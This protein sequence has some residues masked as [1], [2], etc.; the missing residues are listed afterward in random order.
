MGGWCVRGGTY[1]L[2]EGREGGSGGGVL[3]TEREGTRMASVDLVPAV[4]VF[5]RRFGSGC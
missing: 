3:V 5:A 2:C 4:F 1:M